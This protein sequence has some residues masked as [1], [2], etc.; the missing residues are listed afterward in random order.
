MGRLKEDQGAKGAESQGGVEPVRDPG[1]GAEAHLL[2]GPAEVHPAVRLPHPVPAQPGPAQEAAGESFKQ[3]FG[4]FL[5]L[6]SQALEATFNQEKALVGAF[7]VIIISYYYTTSKFPKVCFKLYCR[8]TRTWPRPSSMPSIWPT[9]R[10]WF[11]VPVFR[12]SPG[13]QIRQCRGHGCLLGGEK[14]F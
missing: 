11:P 9:S 4:K 10:G 8:S 1:R 6:K 12:I 7:T 14:C 2:Q 3:T 13:L 5:D